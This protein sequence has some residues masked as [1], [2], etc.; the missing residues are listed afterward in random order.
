[1]AGKFRFE[2]LRQRKTGGADRNARNIQKRLVAE[3]AVVGKYQVEQESGKVSNGKNPRVGTGA[4]GA[5]SA[6]SRE[7]REDSPPLK[8]KYTTC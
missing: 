6:R 4:A 8:R 3:A 5:Q 1:M 7:T 2:R